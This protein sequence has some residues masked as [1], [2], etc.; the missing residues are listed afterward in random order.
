MQHTCTCPCGET[1]F[2]VTGTPLARFNCHCTICQSVY[3]APFADAFLMQI[4]EPFETVKGEIEFARKKA[5][6]G[7]DRGLCPHCHAPL[8]ARFPQ[9][10]LSKLAFVTAARLPAGTN[11][12]P[13]DRHIFYGTR[14]A[15][16]ADDLPRYESGLMSNLSLTPAMIRGLLS[17]G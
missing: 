5:S 8:Y 13:V 4:D 2:S 6:G 10:Y 11:L 3:Q 16:V 14:V 17:R 1:A 9:S 7:I 12:P 15:D